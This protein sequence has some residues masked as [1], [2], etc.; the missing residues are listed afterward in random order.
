[1]DLTQAMQAATANPPPT[2]IDVDRLVTGERRRSRSR[3][4]VAGTA[5]AAVLVGGFVVA[6]Q[7]ARHDETPGSAPPLGTIAS[8][9]PPSCGISTQLDDGLLTGKKPLRPVT[10]SCL[11]GSGR[12]G[13]ALTEVLTDQ[14]PPDTTITPP[15]PAEIAKLVGGYGY[16]TAFRVA[17]GDLEVRLRGSET[18]AAGFDTWRASRCVKV[19]CR[20][21]QHDGRPVLIRTSTG[22]VEVVALHADGTMVSALARGG[23]TEQQLIGIAVAPALTVY[24]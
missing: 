6:Q 8:E 13:G 18:T 17:G 19:T 7:P 20:V 15:L 22:T 24:P 11:A 1:M 10:E 2:G 16:F 3:Y 5:L 4:A 21:E 14:L 23:L 9:E 12:L